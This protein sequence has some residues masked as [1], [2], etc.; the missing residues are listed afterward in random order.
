MAGLEAAGLVD[1]KVEHRLV[2]DAAQIRALVDH[3][4][5]RYGLAPDVIAG[6]FEEI[7]G[8]VWSAYFSGRKA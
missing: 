8:N 5:E 7:A 4:L 1:V 6:A 2:Y 3:D